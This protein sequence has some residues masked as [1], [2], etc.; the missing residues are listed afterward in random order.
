NFLNDR[1]TVTVGNNFNLEGA[2]AGEKATSIAGNVS[3]G[4]KLSRDGRYLLRAYRNDHFIV[5]QGQVIE[6]GVGFSM[7]L[8]YDR[9][10]E[11]L[12]GRK[13]Q[14]KQWRRKVIDRQGRERIEEET[15]KR[16]AKQQ[17][18]QIE[19]SEILDHEASSV[20]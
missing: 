2:Q 8:D 6:T 16:F 19:N 12:R 9:F 1:L 3:I 20:D 15:K 10:K 5:I 4:Y 13:K 11:I 14:Q 17:R 7:T 18:A